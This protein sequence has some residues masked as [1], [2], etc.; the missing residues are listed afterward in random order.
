MYQ[1]ALLLGW[2]GPVNEMSIYR[3]H[4]RLN[5]ACKILVKVLKK[6]DMAINL[7]VDKLVYSASQRNKV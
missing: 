7:D 3:T 6:S 5:S 2:L 1:V 4:I